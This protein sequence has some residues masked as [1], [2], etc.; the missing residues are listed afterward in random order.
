MEAL[1]IAPAL[2]T[3]E[4]VGEVVLIPWGQI[5]PFADQPRTYF[6]QAELQQLADSIAENGQRVPIFVRELDP[7]EP[8]YRYELIDGQRRWHAC[9]MAKVRRMKSIILEV[10]DVIEQF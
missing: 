7:W 4:T 5:R 8:P 10:D 6:N 2:D 9:D 3:P 1:R